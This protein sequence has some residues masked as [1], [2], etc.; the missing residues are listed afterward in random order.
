LLAMMLTTLLLVTSS[1]FP[2]RIEQSE[3][4][5]KAFEAFK[6]EV[7]EGGSNRRHLAECSASAGSGYDCYSD[8]SVFMEK[9]DECWFDFL[10]TDVCCSADIADCCKFPSPAGIGII[11]GAALGIILLIVGIILCSCCLACCAC[12]PCNKH[13]KKRQNA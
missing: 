1:L 2:E 11:V 9:K 6:T 3:S 13:N 4:S 7:L 12:C 5:L 8:C 10:G